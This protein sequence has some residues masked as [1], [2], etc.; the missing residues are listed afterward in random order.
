MFFD[1]YHSLYYG[2]LCLAALA[3]GLLF[4]RLQHVFRILSLMII[5]T[6]ISEL[7]AKYVAYSYQFSNNIIYHFFTPVE[8]GF[9]TAIFAGFLQQRTWTRVLVVSWIILAG[10][11]IVNALY[12]QPLHQSN[13]NIMIMESVF[14]VF[15]SLILFL[16][17]KDDAMYDD[18][19]KEGVFWFNSAVLMYYSF[20]ILVWGFHSFKIY[21][22]RDPP[23]IMYHI[24]LI[25]SAL[26]YTTYV[27]AMYLSKLGNKKRQPIEI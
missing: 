14:L 27:Y 9:Y 25:F 21:T 4:F 22:L 7:T 5:V 3:S 20:N 2:A 8:Y 6:L 19:L 17:M 13:T 16:K 15:F 10:I 23:V 11:G 1:I 26:L 12:I 18:I 24:N